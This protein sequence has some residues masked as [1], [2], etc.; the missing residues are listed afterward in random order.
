VDNLIIGSADRN[1]QLYAAPRSNE[2][3]GNVVSGGNVN[4]VVDSQATTQNIHNNVVV[5]AADYNARSGASLSGTGNRFDN[6]CAWL[7]SGASGIS[8]GPGLTTSANVTANPQFDSS[9]EDG[10]AKV[11]NPECAAKLPAGSRFR[12]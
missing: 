9:L 1:I 11:T 10:V 5:N 8:T 12:P 6:N 3:V 2:V 7:P 4:F